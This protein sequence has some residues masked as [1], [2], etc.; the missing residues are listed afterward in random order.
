VA[1][2]HRTAA[3]QA[4][5][6]LEVEARDG[7]FRA[8]LRNLTL[9]LSNLVDNALKYGK[10]GGRVTLF[11]QVEGDACL[12]EVADDGPGISP[13]HLPRIFERFYRIDKGR[14]REL[15]GTGL[16]LSIAK[17]VVESHGGTIRAE[18]RIGAGTRFVIRIPVPTGSLPTREAPLRGRS[19]SKPS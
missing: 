4:G 6:S 9:A 8:D 7:A 12:L 19:G 11:G 2:Q 17:H 10:E 1:D 14:S 3:K 5:K 18:S 16:G 15:G 13:E